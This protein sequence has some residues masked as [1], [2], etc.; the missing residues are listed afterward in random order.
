MEILISIQFIAGRPML[1][2]GIYTVKMDGE[3]E[4]WLRGEHLNG[5]RV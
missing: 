4:S 5:E 3:S 2:S 1:T